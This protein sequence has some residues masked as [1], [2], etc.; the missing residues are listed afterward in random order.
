M[1]AEERAAD[2]RRPW[3]RSNRHRRRWNF[4]RLMAQAPTRVDD[5][6][7]LPGRNAAAGVCLGAGDAA[8]SGGFF[9]GDVWPAVFRGLVVALP[10][11]RSSCL[12]PGDRL[13]FHGARSDSP[14]AR[15]RGDSQRRID[16]AANRKGTIGQRKLFDFHAGGRRR[17]DWA[18]SSGLRFEFHKRNLQVCSVFGARRWITRRIGKWSSIAGNWSRGGGLGTILLGITAVVVVLG[19]LIGWALRASVFFWVVR[20]IAFF[21]DRDLKLAGSWRLA[22]ATALPARCC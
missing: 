22:A 21:N 2:R 5:S 12:V 9:Q 14:S 8:R 20:L 11:G 1:K 18:A 16:F 15:T 17:A 7:G 3:R 19:L 13:G 6:E 4:D 10:H